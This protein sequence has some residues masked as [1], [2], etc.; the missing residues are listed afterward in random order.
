MIMGFLGDYLAMSN[1]P[2][3]ALS[4][5]SGRFTSRGYSQIADRF[6]V[7]PNVDEDALN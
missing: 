5:G 6:S 2:V 7:I 4:S 1:R 3:A